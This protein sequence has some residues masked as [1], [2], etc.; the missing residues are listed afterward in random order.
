MELFKFLLF[1]ITGAS[2][3]FWISII[4]IWHADILP[5]LFKEDYLSTSGYD[6]FRKFSFSR[7]SKS[8]TMDRNK[9]SLKSFVIADFNPISEDYGVNRL[10]LFNL[11]SLGTMSFLIIIYGLQSGFKFYGL[12]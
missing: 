8:G 4:A 10:Y 9:Y 2:I 3:I 11:L 12:N 5:T 7:V 6:I 1:G